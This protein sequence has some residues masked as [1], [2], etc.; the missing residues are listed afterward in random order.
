MKRALFT[1]LA[2]VPMASAL[3]QSAEPPSQI[4]DLNWMVGTWTGSGKFA[5]HGMEMDMNVTVTCSIEGQFL[6]TVAVN[7]YGAIK[8]EETQYTGYDAEKK[9]YF[10]YS[11]TNVSPAPRVQRG[12]LEG[13]SLVMLS[14]PWTVMGE[15]MT[16]RGATTKVS[17]TKMKMGLDIK[18][19]DKW[20]KASEFELTKK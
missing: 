17:A 9:E 7:D 4:T 1:L 16:A 6:K 5:I 2:M 19:G 8:M 13:N 11:F 20:D 3:A 15:S 14:E 10:A 12:K 18:N